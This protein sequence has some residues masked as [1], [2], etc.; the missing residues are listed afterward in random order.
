[1]AIATLGYGND[2]SD[3]GS[4]ADSP[5]PSIA[6]IQILSLELIFLPQK[7]LEKAI[8]TKLAG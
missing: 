3:K 7:V 4:F 8:A 1:M 6:E 5:I 2:S